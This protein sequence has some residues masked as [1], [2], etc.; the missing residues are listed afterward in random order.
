VLPE[1]TIYSDEHTA[2]TIWG[3]W[4]IVKGAL[5]Q[6]LTLMPRHPIDCIPMHSEC[7]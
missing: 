2:Q 1:T 6:Q 5:G 4:P 3:F 7:L